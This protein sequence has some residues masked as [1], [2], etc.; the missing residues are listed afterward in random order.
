MY[1][2]VI[3]IIYV[4]LCVLIIISNVCGGGLDVG[5]RTL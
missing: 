1:T 5:F 3:I 2:N 4:F